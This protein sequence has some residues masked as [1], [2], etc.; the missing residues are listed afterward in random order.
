MMSNLIIEV[1][2]YLQNNIVWLESLTPYWCLEWLL[3]NA[4]V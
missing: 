2:P 3:D 4:T 1:I